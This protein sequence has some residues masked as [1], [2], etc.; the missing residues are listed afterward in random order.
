MSDQELL[1]V[2][3][4]TPAVKFPFA[5]RVYRVRVVSV[6]DGDTIQ[7]IFKHDA[8]LFQFGLR[9]LGIDTP[10]RHGTSGSI[11]VMADAA[12][13]FAEKT[14]MRHQSCL[15]YAIFTGYDKYGGR[16]LGHLF[17]V[18]PSD[19][20][21]DSSSSFG[22]LML[23]QGLAVPYSGGT[24]RSQEQWNTIAKTWCANSFR[25]I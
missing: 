14:L 25:S 21:P 7:V 3:S 4:G 17:L 13:D 22:T 15:H 24:K 18:C 16:I 10:E 23:Q 1:S 12:R 2:S 11:K 8:T 5:G 6:Y 9:I 20:Y 19:S